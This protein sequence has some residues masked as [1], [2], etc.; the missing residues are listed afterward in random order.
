MVDVDD[1]LSPDHIVLN[2]P[3]TSKAQLFQ[4]LAAMAAAAAGLDTGVVLTAME[5]R[6]RLGTTGIGDGIAIPHARVAG[7]ER[8]F[9]FFIRL[10]TP[11]EYDALDDAPVDLVFLL[12]APESA[13]TLQLKALARIARLLR[14]PET[15]SRLRTLPVI[16]DL[17]QLLRGRATGQ[18]A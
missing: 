9:G 16:A 8:L 13:S 1:F 5:Q 3:A 2:F 17:H 6:E 10:A 4:D 18:A 11:I 7:L 14:D 12:L 15:G